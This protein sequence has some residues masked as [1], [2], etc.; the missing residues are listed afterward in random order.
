[1]LG[2]QCVPLASRMTAFAQQLS[3]SLC[4][5]AT[6]TAKAL[7]FFQGASTRRVGTFLNI[8]HL[9]PHSN[10]VFATW[11]GMREYSSPL[12]SNSGAPRIRRN[13]DIVTPQRGFFEREPD[14]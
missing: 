12:A 4:G 1:M 8:S 9:Y 6:G 10:R 14:L 13:S 11:N 7:T 2:L 5:L 3:G